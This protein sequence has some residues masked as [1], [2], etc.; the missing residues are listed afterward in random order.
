[1]RKSPYKYLL[2]AFIM[3]MLLAALPEPALAATPCPPESGASG[4][5]VVDER[6]ADI[7]ILENGDVRYIETWVVSFLGTNFRFAYRDIPYNRLTGI[8]DWSV[9]EGGTAYTERSSGEYVYDLTGGLS[10]RRITWCFPST[11]NQTRT[12]TLSYTVQGSLAIYD[13]VDQYF[14][15]F[16][17]AD[18]AYTISH[19]TVRLHL[20]ASFSSDQLTLG[21][22]V[23]G[24]ES[25]QIYNEGEIATFGTSGARIIDSQT[26]EFTGGPFYGGDE[27]EIGVRFPHGFVT[28]EKQ[29]WQTIEDRR[30]LFNFFGLSGAIIL[31]LAGILGLYMFWYFRGRDKP[32]GVKA[33]YYPKPPQNIP[34]GV[35]GVLLDENADMED[36]MATLIDLGRR[37][38][39]RITEEEASFFGKKNE[40]T[41]TK[42]GKD[43]ASL[44]PYE[45]AL[46]KAVFGNT[47]QRKLSALKNKF[48]TSLPDIR[49]KMYEEVTKY[50]FFQG[51]PEKVR[52]K[53]GCM[54]F[55]ALGGAGLLAFGVYQLAF[56]SLHLFDDFYA[57]CFSASIMV[58][59]LGLL[60]IARVMPRKTATGARAAMQWTAFRN[61]LKNVDKYQDVQ[62]AKEQF[63]LYLPYAIAFGLEKSWVARFEKTDVPIPMWYDP[64][65]VHRP[66][67]TSGSGKVT[68]RPA[69]T[70]GGGAPSLDQAADSVFGGLQSMSTGL[71]S[72]LDQASST[73]TSAPSSS[74]SG[75]GGGGFSGGGGG[76]G[77]SSGFG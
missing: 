15:K 60:L 12:F 46:L 59:P 57:L 51:N 38:Y 54:G 77:G 35:V 11:S 10:N 65:P 37:G 17:E 55:A 26:I 29:L 58:F 41:F 66:I 62:K 19:S 63:E 18:R 31:T 33:E 67:S 34:P 39:L 47:R 76:G 36:I 7:T 20:P 64:Y 49:A 69:P 6:N 3:V 5:V 74:G 21:G 43:E 28:S 72:M 13:D 42:L 2:I 71:F 70:G 73:F 68:G 52:Q 9:A 48:Y 30:P 53:Y 44:L 23:N 50:G 32:V 27:W 14:W 61:Y 45:K 25:L 16:I 75:G 1:M 56:N 24:L 8:T 22:F 40:F 4:Y